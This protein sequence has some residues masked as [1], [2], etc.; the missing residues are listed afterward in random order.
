MK[1]MKIFVSEG[2]KSKE[3]ATRFQVLNLYQQKGEIIF[4]LNIKVLISQYS[5]QISEILMQMLFL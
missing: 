1:K 5:W 2:E 3:E 4:S